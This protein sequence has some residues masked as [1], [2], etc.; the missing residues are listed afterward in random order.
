VVVVGAVVFE[1]PSKVGMSVERAGV[2]TFVGDVVLEL[3]AG[4]LVIW[5]ANTQ[6]QPQLEWID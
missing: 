5:S 4:L 1:P 2:G 6:T 3:G